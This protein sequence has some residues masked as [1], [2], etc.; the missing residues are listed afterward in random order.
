MVQDCVS[1]RIKQLLSDDETLLDIPLDACL[2]PRSTKNNTT[3]RVGDAAIEFCKK[4]YYNTYKQI[5]NGT[6][7]EPVSAKE[8][9][10]SDGSDVSS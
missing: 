9:T 5:L 2:I 3:I 4:K 1:A 7:T 6:T 8:D 10:N